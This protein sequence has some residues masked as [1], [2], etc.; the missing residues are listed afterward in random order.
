MFISIARRD[1]ETGPELYIQ[2]QASCC[3]CKYLD[4]KETYHS[5]FHDYHIYTCNHPT[6]KKNQ[7]GQ[8]TPKFVPTPT[9]C[10]LNGKIKE[11]FNG[12][13]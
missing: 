6:M 3:N 5:I 10:P 9:N 8:H 13:R 12:L 11:F 7:L 1:Y 4:G 2:Y